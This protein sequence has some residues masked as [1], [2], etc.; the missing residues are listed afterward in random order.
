MSKLIAH[1]CVLFEVGFEV[2]QHGNLAPHGALDDRIH[3]SCQATRLVV[4]SKCDTRRVSG[5]GKLVRASWAGWPS[6][7]W[8]RM[9]LFGSHSVTS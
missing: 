8:K 4:Q 3:Q 2:C 9:M 5:G 7:T 1:L 6:V